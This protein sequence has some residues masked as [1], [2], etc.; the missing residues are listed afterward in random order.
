[1]VDE[2][3]LAVARY[4]GIKTVQIPLWSMNTKVDMQVLVRWMVFRFLYGR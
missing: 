4:R 2:Y 1:M 3:M